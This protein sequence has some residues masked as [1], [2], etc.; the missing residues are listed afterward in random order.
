MRIFAV[1]ANFGTRNDQYVRRLLEEYRAVPGAD[2]L[3]LTNVAKSFG[4]GVEVVVRPPVGDPWT[5]PFAHKQIL[6]DRCDEYDLFIYSEDD[7]LITGKNINA[8]S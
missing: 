6:A 1:I 5:F 4:R 7:T 8:S 2:V 3:V